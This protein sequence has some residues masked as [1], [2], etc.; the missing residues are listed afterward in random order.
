PQ[1]VL[2]RFTCKSHASQKCRRDLTRLWQCSTHS[3]F[4]KRRTHSQPWPSKTL[5]VAWR[6]GDSLLPGWGACMEEGQDRSRARENRQPKR[7]RSSVQRLRVSGGTSQP[8]LSFTRTR[9]PLVTRLACVRS[10]EHTSELQSLT[11][12]VCR[13]LL[14]QK[15][16]Y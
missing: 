5:T 7:L 9:G 10:E 11:N 13:L 4:Q 8:L 2:A 16:R 3:L 14:E 1:P 15:K 12:L 6:I